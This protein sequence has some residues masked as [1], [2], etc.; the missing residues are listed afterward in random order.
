LRSGRNGLFII[1]LLSLALPRVGIAFDKA[2]AQSKYR[3]G[4][5]A[6]GQGRW[7]DASHLL[8]ESYNCYPHSLT[9]YCISYSCVQLRHP[10]PAGNYAQKALNGKPP[11]D[12]PYRTD[13]V[14]IRDWAQN[15]RSDPY[16]TAVGKAD[17]PNASA[18]RP[19]NPRDPI[20]TPTGPSAGDPFADPQGNPPKEVAPPQPPPQKAA[21]DLTGSWQCSDGGIYFVRQIG[22][23]VWWYGKQSTDAPGWANVFHGWMKGDLL[24]GEWADV[25]PYDAMNSGA[26]TLRVVSSGV[27]LRVG[28][29]PGFGGEKWAR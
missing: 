12:D 7:E 1:A 27:M 26:L 3:E 10:F 6:M 23:S 29:A 9:A 17:D 21:V 18:P 22:A 16:F 20:P 15:A 2:C 4:R 28:D 24:S 11:L 5:E 19:P 14:V 8:I 25:P 13:A